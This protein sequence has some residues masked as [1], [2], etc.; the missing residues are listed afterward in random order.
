MPDYTEVLALPNRPKI[1]LVLSSGG[2]KACAAFELFDFLEK[3]HIPIDL[4]VG[5]SGGSLA[6]AYKATGM[7]ITE[8]RQTV[9]L[10]AKRKQ[11]ILQ[12]D[13]QAIGAL[14]NLP[15]THFNKG[16][17]FDQGG[18]IVKNHVRSRWRPAHRRS[19]N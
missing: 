5:C 4:L 18:G 13:Y 1:G 10:F 14:L 11:E 7:T 2:I 9:D 8:M 12:L 3:A 15:F 17:R 16:Q 6:C 19:A